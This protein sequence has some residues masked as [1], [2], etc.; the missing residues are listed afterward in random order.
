MR[1]ILSLALTA[2]LTVALA[3]PTSAAVLCKKPTGV[4]A[5]RQACKKKEAPVD[6]A[7]FGAVGP[8]GSESVRPGVR[9]RQV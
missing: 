6:L 8:P 4:I 2:S 5:V 1:P 3:A 9:A 7:E